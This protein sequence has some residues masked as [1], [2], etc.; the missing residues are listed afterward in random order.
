MSGQD[1][2]HPPSPQI[3]RRLFGRR[4]GKPLRPSRQKL[5]DELLPRLRIPR[6][7]EGE[8]IDPAALF[9]F[10]PKAVWFEVGFG[11]GEHLAWQAEHNPETGFIGCEP[12]ETGLAGLCAE[13]E[14]RDLH[15]V[16]V[17]EDDAALLLAALKPNSLER[18]FVL[19]PDP[20]PKKRHHKRRFISPSRLD[21]IARALR[22]GA[23][24]RL[25]TDHP[26][27]AAWML[28]HLLARDDFEWLAERP[29]DWQVRPAD[30]P[31]TRY[32]EKALQE[33]R[34]S[35]YLRFRY[36]QAA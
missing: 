20:W 25:G 34:K 12:F 31:P 11:K 1:E 15:N 6:P 36:R 24:L 32:E 10:P 33:G 27:Y 35:V 13:I 23:E 29:A 22:D 8:E 26:G 16:R 19:F 14:D 21:L 30:W 2:S 4:K 28:R 9:D 17:F 5:M 7:G 18:V 3:E